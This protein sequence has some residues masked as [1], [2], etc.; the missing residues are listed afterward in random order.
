MHHYKGAFSMKRFFQLFNDNHWY[1]IA[2][3]I[4]CAAILWT[5]GCESQCESIIN[6]GKQ[7]NRSELY[8]EINYV[9]G[10]AK[11]REENLDKQDEIK[12]AILDAGNLISQTGSINP[13][14]LINLA[15][16]IGAISFGLDRHRR[17]KITRSQ[18]ITNGQTP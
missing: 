14:G 18:I 1:L 11:A 7:V 16:T 15:A 12:Q 6:A 13:S 5:Y 17:Y 10:L 9:V 4:I 8:N 2:G 3:A